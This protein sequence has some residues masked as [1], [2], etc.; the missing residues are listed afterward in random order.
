MMVGTYIYSLYFDL[1][2]FVSYSIWITVT[3]AD[4]FWA[5]ACTKNY[6]DEQDDATEK[7]GWIM[8][9]PFFMGALFSAPLGHMSDI[10]GYRALLAM[11]SPILLIATHFQLA[12]SPEGPIFPL[13][14]QGIAFAIYCA[15]IWPCV[16]RISFFRLFI[17]NYHKV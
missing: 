12:Y 6:C 5:E 16:V 3:C 1:F 13:I 7:A 8:S 15:I 10:Y 9:I 17:L 14:L 2:T 4:D 11:C